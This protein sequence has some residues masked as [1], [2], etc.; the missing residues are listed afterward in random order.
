MEAP[1]GY[2]KKS[3]ILTYESSTPDVSRGD[4]QC[5][6]PTLKHNFGLLWPHA[7]RMHLNKFP[8]HPA[9][10]HHKFWDTCVHLFL[11]ALREGNNLCIPPQVLSY[12]YTQ[13][14]SNPLLSI[15]L[16][17]WLLRPPI[18]SFR[19]WQSRA[20]SILGGGERGVMQRKEKEAESKVDGGMSEFGPLISVQTILLKRFVQ[21]LWHCP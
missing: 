17:L 5:P 14:F 6:A 12:H 1:L 16:P 19:R 21:F 11:N 3:N 10:G 8:G 9:P 4:F 13:L 2:E 7:A 20:P 15:L 18:D